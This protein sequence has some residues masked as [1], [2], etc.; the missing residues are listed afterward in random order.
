MGRCHPTRMGTGGVGGS[1]TV[2][3]KS[4]SPRRGIAEP[5][6]GAQVRTK[7]FETVL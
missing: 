5:G 2:V 7:F 3:G 4:P 6:G 1:E